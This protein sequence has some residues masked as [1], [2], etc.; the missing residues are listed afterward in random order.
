[1]KLTPL[2]V[3]LTWTPVLSLPAAT[4]STDNTETLFGLPHDRQHGLLLETTKQQGISGMATGINFTESEADSY[5]GLGVNRVML[6]KPGETHFYLRVRKDFQFDNEDT[7]GAEFLYQKDAGQDSAMDVHATIML[8]TY[9]GTMGK[10]LPFFRLGAEFDRSTLEADKEENTQRFYAL[11]TLRG[12]WL[13]SPQ[14]VQ[15]GAVY[16]RDALHDTSGWKLI[17]NWEPR[18][19]M[20]NGFTLGNRQFYK[21]PFTLANA[22][23]SKEAE[24][25]PPLSSA[26]EAHQ[27]FTFIRPTLSLESALSDLANGATRDE[28][29]DSAL[30]ICYGLH[31]GIGLFKGR[32]TLSGSIKGAHP[33]ED[34]GESHFFTELRAE[35]RPYVDSESI[36]AFI[37]WQKG[38]TAPTYQNIDR[39]SA[40]LTVK[41]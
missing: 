11:L 16:D 8:D 33:I 15:F 1:M 29:A 36:S 40:G 9:V 41:F 39:V 18:F 37:S 25:A 22:N 38:E 17:L 20:K 5:A 14:P 32:V 19:L 34:V 10:N 35:F 12:A 21:A 2:F 28:A 4:V 27:T 7:P 30:C 3:A 26:N 23:E 31:A 13:D 6:A 24:K